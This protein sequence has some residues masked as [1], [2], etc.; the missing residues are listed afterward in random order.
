MNWTGHVNRMDTTRKVSHGGGGGGGEKEVEKE[1]E[2][3][4]SGRINAF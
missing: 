4:K 1:E 2:M 3:Y